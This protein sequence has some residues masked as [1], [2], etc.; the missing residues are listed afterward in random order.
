MAIRDANGNFHSEINGRFIEKQEA[1]GRIDGGDTEYTSVRCIGAYEFH[2]L[3]TAHHLRHMMELGFSSAKEYERAAVSFFN[4]DRG[5]LYFSHA[6]ERYYRYDEKTGEMAVASN[7]VIH[8][9]MKNTR[10]RFSKITKQDKLEEIQY[11]RIGGMPHLRH[12]V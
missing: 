3:D 8:T 11:E 2:R 1:A 9:Y 6:R 10:T 7:G 12:K 4:S 5:K